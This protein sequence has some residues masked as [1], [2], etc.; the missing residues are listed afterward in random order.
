MGMCGD[1]G[2]YFHEQDGHLCACCLTSG[3]DS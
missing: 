1:C 2:A 3:E